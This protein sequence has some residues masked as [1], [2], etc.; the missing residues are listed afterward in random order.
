MRCELLLQRLGRDVVDRAGDTFNV[1]LALLEQGQQL[2]VV[3]ADL[4][5]EFVDADA[6]S[7]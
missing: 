2:L 3:H 7:V 4:L 1:V 5:G 6:H